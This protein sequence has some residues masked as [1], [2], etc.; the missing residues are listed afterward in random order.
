MAS[1]KIKCPVEGIIDLD[2]LPGVP[3]ESVVAII[4]CP[5]VQ[6]LRAIRQLGFTEYVYP[7]ATHTR[8][9]H[10]LGAFQGGQRALTKLRE[11]GVDIPDDWF[12]A[13]AVACLLHDVGHG[14]FSHTFEAVTGHSHEER[15]Q[16]I[17]LQGP[18]L[19]PCLRSIQARLPERVVELIT[20]TVSEEDYRFLSD[21]VSSALDCDR[22][23]YLRRDAL[24]TGARYG[25]FDRD[26][27]LGEMI[28]TEDREAIVVVEKGRAAVE[29]YL[30][31]RYHMFQNV[32]LHKTSRGFE[33]AFGQLCRRLR[34]LGPTALPPEARALRRLQPDALE[35]EEFLMLDD[36][37]L[38]VEI[39]LLLDHE[40]RTVRGLARALLWRRPLRQVTSYGRGQVTREDLQRLLT[41]RREAA[42]DG[43]L[44]PDTAV[45]VDAAQDV[46]YRPYDPEMSRRGLRIRH[47]DGRL[48][49]ITEESPTIRALAQKL[50][51]SR[52]Y[53]MAED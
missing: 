27:I 48:V 21:L 32:Y 36:R 38:L 40:D 34:H 7:G 17:V 12:V 39:G 31:G 50:V 19:S 35:L 24:H 25:A 20:H 4:D 37:K 10:S 52:V 47:D 46:P 16:E 5:E 28:P 14:P 51:T 29:Q 1:T 8:F 13:T 18:Q 45:W 53:W 49:D 15:T 44:D 30:I 22:M 26:W 43:G 11:R 3:A 41:T 2:L 23:D 42:H 9:A 33:G 6:R